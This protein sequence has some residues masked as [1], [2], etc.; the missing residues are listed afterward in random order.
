ME[1]M[2][3]HYRLLMKLLM[4]ILQRILVENDNEMKELIS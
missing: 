1:I 3:I 4:E 2:V